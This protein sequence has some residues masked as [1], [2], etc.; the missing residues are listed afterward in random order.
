MSIGTIRLNIG[1]GA[2]AMRAPG[3][4][5]VDA[6][7]ESAADVV[8]RV[9]PLPWES[10]TVSEI[11]AGHFLEHLERAEAADFLDECWRVLRPGGRLGL[12]V[13]DMREILRRYIQDEP[14][15]ME[16]PQGQHRDLRDLD[17]LCEAIIFSTLQPSRHQWAYDA[18]TLARTLQ[19]AGFQILGEFDRYHDPRIGVGAWYQLG[20]DA[21]KP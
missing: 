15:P 11:Y 5:N 2:Y 18:D 17:E 16:W 9:P 3:W 19:R 8:L 6:V 20:I 13:P 4:V 21:S 12:V 1:C 10:A 7:A 14:A